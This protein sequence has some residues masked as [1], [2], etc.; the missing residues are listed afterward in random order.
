MYNMY[1]RQGQIFNMHVDIV[2]LIWFFSDHNNNCIM[3]TTKGHINMVKEVI[4]KLCKHIVAQTLY[5][6]IGPTLTLQWFE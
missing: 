4:L 5:I 6:V 3:L 1:N 2:K